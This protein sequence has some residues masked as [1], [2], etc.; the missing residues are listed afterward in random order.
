MSECNLKVEQKAKKKKTNKTKRAV[1]T[2]WKLPADSCKPEAAGARP[3][4][5]GAV[6]AVVVGD[7]LGAAEVLGQEV[8]LVHGGLEGQ[9]MQSLLRRA[10]GLWG[11]G[12]K[13]KRK[14]EQHPELIFS[15]CLC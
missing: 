9:L 15:K 14:H 2:S 3:K 6:A 1:V 4:V 11:E 5:G 12:W 8:E 13:A 7:A 10:R